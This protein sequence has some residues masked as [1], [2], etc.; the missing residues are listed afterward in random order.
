MAEYDV[1]RREKLVARMSNYFPFI[2]DA[3]L[4]LEENNAET[5][6]QLFARARIILVE[7][8]RLRQP[9]PTEPEILTERLALD[10]AIRKVEFEWVAKESAEKAATHV[11]ESR[12]RGNFLKQYL[13]PI[14]WAPTLFRFNGIGC[15]VLGRFD[16]PEV[17]PAFFCVYMFTFL[18]LPLT[19]LNI[20][21]VT[22]GRDGLHGSFRFY[23]SI[24]MSDFAKTYPGALWRLL[25]SAAG[26]T[27]AM[28][29]VFV[30]AIFL[31]ALLRT[32]LRGH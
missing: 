10:D 13:R 29:G 22:G 15:T 14:N 25:L 30:A 20:Y 6:E 32:M 26:H 5:R 19:P 9:A 3:V 7:Q 18:F 16:S 21:L 31:V 24:N 1:S 2:A 27:L 11:Q 28:L 4:K 23:G 17:A 8:L 12:E